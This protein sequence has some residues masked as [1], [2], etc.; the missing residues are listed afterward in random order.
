MGGALNVAADG[1][2]LILTSWVDNDVR[3]WNQ[4]D[5]AIKWRK[6]ELLAPVSAA[7][8]GDLIVVAEHGKQRVI[9][10]DVNGEV[11]AI[12]AENLPAPT[13]LAVEGGALYVSDRTLG[14]I[15]KL[16]ENGETLAKPLVVVDGLDSPEGFVWYNNKIAVVEADPG[17]VTLVDGDGGKVHLA[18]I[19]PGSQAASDFQPPS[20]V[21]NGITADDEGN[22]YIP[23]ETNRVLYRLSNPF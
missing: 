17:H 16:A 14:Q 8:Y 6:T 22:L 20:Q 21:F 10:V 2:D 19:P 23:G 4:Q 18:D 7:R 15:L 1:E 12:F 11:V 9:G 13:G 3:I 5:Q